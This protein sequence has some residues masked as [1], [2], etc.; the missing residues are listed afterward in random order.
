MPWSSRG[1]SICSGQPALLHAGR[2]QGRAGDSSMDTT[3]VLLPTLFPVC[4]LSAA[5]CSFTRAPQ[6]AV[7]LPC[8]ACPGPTTNLTVL[9][10]IGSKHLL[11]LPA[12]PACS[13]GCLHLHVVDR[14]GEE[15]KHDAIL[16]SRNGATCAHGRSSLTVC[17]GGSPP[18]QQ[19]SMVSSGCC[20]AWQLTTPAQRE[21]CCASRYAS[22]ESCKAYISTQIFL[23]HCPCKQFAQISA[24]I[25]FR[26]VGHAAPHHPACS[27]CAARGS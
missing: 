5:T 6:N 14:V 13:L 8:T 9:Q 24:T 22:I 20:W 3:S 25:F 11:L 18:S 27:G 19:L 1:G 23:Q 4:P 16:R 21:A 2:S 12:L 15:A 17:W 26:D 7:L 10:R